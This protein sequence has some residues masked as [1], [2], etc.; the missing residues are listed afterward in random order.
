MK[1]IVVFAMVI[2]FGLC[3]AGMSFAAKIKCT[4]EGVDGEKVTMTCQDADK[5]APGAKVKVDMPKK[6]GIE[7]C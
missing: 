7:G 6:G 5:L 2:A 3:S 4:V 1:K